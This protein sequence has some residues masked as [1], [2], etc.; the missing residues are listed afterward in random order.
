LIDDIPDQGATPCSS[1]R[2][3]KGLTPSYSVVPLLGVFH[4]CE[5]GDLVNFN[6]VKTFSATKRE[7]RETLGERVTSWIAENP[8]IVIVDKTVSQSSD[9]EFHCITIV[10]FYKG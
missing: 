1:T 5:S 6:G 8:K 7:G 4:L 10:I 2:E 3:S 9:A